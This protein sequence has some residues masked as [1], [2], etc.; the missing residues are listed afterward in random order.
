MRID[1]T[2]QYDCWI[3]QYLDHQSQDK[4]EWVYPHC[5]HT[6]T[7]S[8]SVFAFRRL[9]HTIDCLLGSQW[10]GPN[11]IYSC[12]LYTSYQCHRAE[13]SGDREVIYRY[14]ITKEM[15][16]SWPSLLFVV[17]IVEFKIF[18][19]KTVSYTHLVCVS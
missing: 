16:Y 3:I 7:N 13:W 18:N 1:S 11:M 8:L 17:N 12:L 10:C 4:R 14:I 5:S 2:L 9:R 19:L 15:D 6:E